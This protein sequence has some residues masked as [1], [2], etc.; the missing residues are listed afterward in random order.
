MLF[1]CAAGAVRVE[2][3]PNEVPLIVVRGISFGVRSRLMSQQ[4]IIPLFPLPVTVF[5]G[6]EL[7]LHIF[8]ERY[9]LMVGLCL[10]RGPQSMFGISY[11]EKG[12][13]ADI[14]CAVSVERVLER[15][16]D[17]RLD[18]RARGRQRYIL[19]EFLERQSFAE[20]RVD[21]FEDAA[22][23]EA[24]YELRERVVA[25]HTRFTELTSGKPVMHDYSMSADVSFALASD[26]GLPHPIRQQLLEMLSEKARL[27]FLATY[28]QKANED[29]STRREIREKAG[30]NGH[31]KH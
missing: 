3:S 20:A 11:V 16:P 1:A 4:V 2:R 8:E 9:K 27:D 26:A 29:I 15:Y 5:P 14:G 17:G 7:P 25:L 23:E 30:S 21:F 10:E 13:M 31:L 12:T 6:E 24:H 28:F 19:R 18:I 22:D